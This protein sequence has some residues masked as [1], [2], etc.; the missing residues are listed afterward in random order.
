MEFARSP[1][2]TQTE[3]GDVTG[4]RHSRFVGDEEIP[5]EVKIGRPQRSADGK[6]FS[7]PFQ[8]VGMEDQ[9]VKCVYGIGSVQAL[10]LVM[11]MI[12]AGLYVVNQRCGGAIRSLA[13]ESDLGF[14]ETE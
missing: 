3:L 9:Q 4:I 2:K 7:C 6:D 12:G 14:S 10:Q 8:I 1:I 5:P 11:K 13:S